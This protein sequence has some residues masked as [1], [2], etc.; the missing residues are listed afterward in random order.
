MSETQRVACRQAAEG[1]YNSCL[2]LAMTA[3]A[4]EE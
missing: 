4:E 2:G 1:S 3:V